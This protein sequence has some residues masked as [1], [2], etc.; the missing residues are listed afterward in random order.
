[1]QS[2][3]FEKFLWG[4]V[5]LSGLLGATLA[6]FLT[7]PSL[8]QPYALPEL[9]L[10]LATAFML[11]AGLV[12][13]LTGNRFGIEGRRY[14]LFL[15]CGF[16]VMAVTWLFFLV[17]PAIAQRSDDRTELWAAM[18]GRMFGWALVAVA[19]FARGRARHRRI[20]LWNGLAACS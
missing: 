19:P 1:M 3:R 7:Y 18:A 6:L 14:D 5:L 15:F 11:V 13:V 12:A 8:R 20:S 9:R 2:A 4:Q 17:L 10:V 16:F